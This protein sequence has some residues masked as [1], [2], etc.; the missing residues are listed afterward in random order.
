MSCKN[1]RHDCRCDGA[2]HCWMLFHCLQRAMVLVSMVPG[3]SALP[4][5]LT[6]NAGS[7][8]DCDK[9]TSMLWQS[10]RTVL[11]RAAWKKSMEHGGWGGGSIAAVPA[12][13]T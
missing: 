13:T 11:K 5:A 3:S 4:K 1:V 7:K 8:H 6:R 10:S 2:I 12:A 9:P